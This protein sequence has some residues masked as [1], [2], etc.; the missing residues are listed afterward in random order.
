MKYVVTDTHAFVVVF[1]SNPLVSHL[2]P[3]HLLHLVQGPASLTIL[4]SEFKEDSC[5][6]SVTTDKRLLVDG[7]TFASASPN[8]LCLFVASL[9]T[10]AESVTIRGSSF[11]RAKGMGVDIKNGLKV[12]VTGSTFEANDGQGLH[13]KQPAAANA[14]LMMEGNTFKENKL[15][16]LS[17][18]GGAAKGWMVNLYNTKFEK[19]GFVVDPKSV[20]PIGS[21]GGGV[22]A[23]G[24]A[25]L[26]VDGCEFSGNKGARGG[27]IAVAGRE[28]VGNVTLRNVKIEGNVAHEGG[29]VYV[30]ELLG[31]V[32]VEMVGSSIKDNDGGNL[33]VKSGLGAGQRDTTFKCSDCASYLAL[34]GECT[35]PGSGTCS[36]LKGSVESAQFFKEP[37]GIGVAVAISLAGAAGIALAVIF[38]RARMINKKKE[39][40]DGESKFD[41]V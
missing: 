31:K 28:E 13:V 33:V 24:V 27:A 1:K 3:L 37:L 29:A 9:S 39:S 30:N 35:A 5:G 19:N 8:P 12:E 32:V 21:E 41:Q 7:S 15:G 18:E 6:I 22:A 20:V 38:G 17:L 2:F 11:S 16:G 34:N 14:T 4:N 36:K 10:T 40:A 23:I 25:T 26:E